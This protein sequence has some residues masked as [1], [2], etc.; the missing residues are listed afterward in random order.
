MHT[1]AD[2]IASVPFLEDAEEDFVRYLVTQ[3]HPTVCSLHLSRA[4]A[5]LLFSFRF[6]FTCDCSLWAAA[7]QE[8][9]GC[10]QAASRQLCIRLAFSAQSVCHFCCCFHTVIAM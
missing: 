1:C 10:P 5:A 9:D 4:V 8:L 2:L 3:L 7:L 6:V